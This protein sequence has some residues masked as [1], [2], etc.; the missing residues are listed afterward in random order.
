VRA[1]IELAGPDEQQ[2]LPSPGA[3]ELTWLHRD[4]PGYRPG[5]SF[6]EAVRA[7]TLPAGVVQAF[8]HG[9]LGAMR[10]LRRHFV[11][12]RGIPADR[13]SLSGYWRRGKD[14]DGFQA[15]K[16]EDARRASDEPDTP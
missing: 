14:E 6:V 8:V 5:D 15:E 9:E 2:P 4:T 12:E 11:H 13:L 16:A 10:D 7:L 1:L 3:V